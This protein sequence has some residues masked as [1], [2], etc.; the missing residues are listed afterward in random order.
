MALRSDSL[1][2]YTCVGFAEVG[3]RRKPTAT[4]TTSSS[5][6]SPH[7]AIGMARSQSLACG[8]VTALHLTCCDALG[9]ESAISS[10]T[11]SRSGLS[12]MRCFA[13]CTWQL[14][15]FSVRRGYPL[16]PEI[17]QVVIGL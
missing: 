7:E 2:A 4:L 5:I 1:P 17:F 13:L 12:H 8:A 15:W 6:F 10:M 14:M 16:G 3:P 11:R 9:N